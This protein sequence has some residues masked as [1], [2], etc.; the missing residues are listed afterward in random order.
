MDYFLGSTN[1]LQTL[2]LVDYGITTNGLQSS[3]MD[4]FLDSTNGLQTLPLVDYGITTNGLQT[5][6][7]DYFSTILQYRYG[8]SIL[9]NIFS[10]NTRKTVQISIF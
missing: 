5:P 1:G 9:G 3:L 8:V 4:Y 6:L 2:P 10:R 7:M